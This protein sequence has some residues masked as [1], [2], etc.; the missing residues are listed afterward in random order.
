LN[1]FR[2]L[3][4]DVVFE[5]TVITVANGH[6]EAPDGQRFDR[7]LVHHPGA[8]VVVPMVDDETVLLVRQYRAAVEAEV[9][10][11]PAGKRDVADEPPDITAM[12]ELAEEVG[13]RAGRLELL[14][15]FYNSPGFSD[16][17]TWLYLARDLS[18]VA[19][20]R[21][22]IEEQ[23]MTLEEI[24]LAD[25]DRLMASGEITDAKTIIGLLLADRRIKGESAPARP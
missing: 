12:R 7:D 2:K 10:E 20:D 19:D 4:E 3:G 22:G 25:V 23:S 9:L 11:M 5:G 1:A 13:R 6:F 24:K 8:V 18:V 16:E 14:A 21:Q 17:L 15:N